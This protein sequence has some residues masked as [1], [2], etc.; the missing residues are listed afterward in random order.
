MLDDGQYSWQTY[1]NMAL[2]AGAVV[3]FAIAPP[4]GI[5]YWITAGTL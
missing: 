3:A 5:A 2:L 1:A 4:A